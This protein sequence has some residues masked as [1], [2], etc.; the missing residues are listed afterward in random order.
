VA[1]YVALL[2]GINVGRAKRVAMADLR[3]IVEELG[4]ADVRTLLNSGNVAFSG[5]RGGTAGI[6]SRIEAALASRVGVESRTIVLT[7]RELAGIVAENTLTG[8][9]KDPSRLLVVVLR[10]ARDRRLLEPLL[11]ESWR[12]EAFALGKRAAYVWCPKGVLESRLVEAVGRRLKDAHTI[13]NW[14]TTTKLAAL[15]GIAS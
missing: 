14:S 9:A 4:Y 2:R 6:A 1:R 7:D 15:A 5:P 11:E 8:V 3:W 13:R 10:A 12:P